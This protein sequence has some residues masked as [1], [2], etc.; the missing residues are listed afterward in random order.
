MCFFVKKEIDNFIA[1]WKT[2]RE[3]TF[4]WNICGCFSC[5]YGVLWEGSRYYMWNVSRLYMCVIFRVLCHSLL[6]HTI[7]ESLIGCI[8]CFVPLNREECEGG[9]V[10]KHV[11][12][13]Y[14]FWHIA[15]WAIIGI[16][17]QLGKQNNDLKWN[18]RKRYTICW[19]L[20]YLMTWSWQCL[21]YNTIAAGTLFLW[22][23][24]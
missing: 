24:H 1:W 11:F 16:T 14:L 7:Q 21:W 2:P 22:S 13:C 5:W 20:F 15:T 9:C 17:W 3:Y 6:K 23:A 19:D 18:L 12:F 8:E 4:Q 10:S